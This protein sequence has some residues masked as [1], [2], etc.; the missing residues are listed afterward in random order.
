MQRA[1]AEVEAG[2][3]HDD[4]ELLHAVGRL[5]AALGHAQDRRLLEIDERDVRLVVHLVVAGH[6]R[7]PLLGEA[8]VLGDQLVGGVGILDDAAD[9]LGDELAP[10]RVRGGIEQQ[11]GVVAGELGE[12]G[13][14]PHLLEERLPLCFGVV[15]R[16]AIVHGV[17]EAGGRRVQRLAH[18]FEVGA[19]LRLLGWA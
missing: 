14:V 11:V 3:P 7:R 1:G 17:E 5:D 18:R 15:E 6:E 10:L 9:L 4:V 8:V 2:R 12:A 13:A 16:G 19:E